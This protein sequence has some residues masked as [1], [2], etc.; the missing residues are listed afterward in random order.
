MYIIIV[1]YYTVTTYHQIEYNVVVKNTTS[2]SS[3]DPSLYYVINGYY[4]V[5]YNSIVVRWPG[6]VRCSAAEMLV[7]CLI[8]TRST[9]VAD[10]Y[11]TQYNNNI[12]ILP[13][14]VVQPFP[15]MYTFR[16]SSTGRRYEWARI[17]VLK[18]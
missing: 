15:A 9:S 10:N 14:H 6:A 16:R 17:V 4:I 11:C 13:I 5:T 2:S 3:D 12:I 18:R 1:Y 8:T 7:H